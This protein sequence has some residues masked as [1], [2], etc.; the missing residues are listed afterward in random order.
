MNAE[1]EYLERKT[2]LL[3]ARDAARLREEVEAERLRN[4]PP[5]N[6]GA[7]GKALVLHSRQPRSY[8]QIV[9]RS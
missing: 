1:K 5:A 8:S 4:E 2:E 7:V 6:S 9:R 3:E